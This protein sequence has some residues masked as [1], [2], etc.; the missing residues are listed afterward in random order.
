MATNVI[1][2]EGKPRFDVPTAKIWEGTSG[3]GH[4]ATTIDLGSG[5]N[6]EA[7][8]NIYGLKNFRVHS[9]SSGAL[10]RAKVVSY[11]DTTDVLTVDAWDNGTPSDSQA[12]YLQSKRID[13]P[14]CQRLTESFTPDFIVKKMLDGTIRRT[15]R[16]Y[17]YSASLDYQRY[18]HKDEMQLLRDLYNSTIS[19]ASN[20]GYFFYPRVDNTALLYSIDID[21]D[22]AVSFYQLKQHQGH[23]GVIIKIVGLNRLASIPF[24][25]PVLDLSKV[26]MDSAG[27]YVIDDTGVYVQED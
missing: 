22:Y 20:G 19:V 11:N 26:I 24:T 27:E 8:D 12:T 1:H 15:K 25:D 3:T 18:L 17:Y 5:I 14:Y 6:L 21:P 4:S 13:L 23:G 7:L 10:T 2:G 9:L 16:G